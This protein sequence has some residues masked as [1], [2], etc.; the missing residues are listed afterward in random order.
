MTLPGRTE[1]LTCGK[2]VLEAIHTCKGVPL[3]RAAWNRKLDELVAQWHHGDSTAEL[4]ECLGM[5]WGEYQEWT[6]NHKVLPLRWPG[7]GIIGM[8]HD[9]GGSTYYACAECAACP[10]PEHDRDHSLDCSHRIPVEW[11]DK[12]CEMLG[13]G[14]FVMCSR[15]ME[16][17]CRLL[18]D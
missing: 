14:R 4:H 12:A 1:C 6:K 13:P 17:P 2:W 8:P 7:A 16:P 5:T 11:F 9:L 3:T 18:E 10:C 15:C